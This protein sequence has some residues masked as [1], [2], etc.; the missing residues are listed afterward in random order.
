MSS[1]NVVLLV[2]WA[3][4]GNGF[5]LGDLLEERGFRVRIVGIP[6]YSLRNRQVKWRKALLWW[7]YVVLGYRGAQLARR[8]ASTVVAWNFIPGVFAA[9]VNQVFREPRVNVVSLNAIAFSKGAMHSFARRLV[10]RR[11]FASGR[12]WL[13]VNS[14]ALRTL[15]GQWFGFTRSRVEV[16]Y[17]CWSPAYKVGGPNGDD[18]GYVFAGG[19]AARDWPLVLEIAEQLPDVLFEVVAPR[20]DWPSSRSCPPNVHVQFDITEEDFYSLLEGSRLV[21]MPLNSTVTAGLIVLMRA[22][23]LGRIVVSTR[24]PATETCYPREL[25]HLLVEKGDDAGFCALIETLWGDADARVMAARLL[26]DHV[27]AERSPFGFADRV[28]EL[29]RRADRNVASP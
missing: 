4:D 18:E 19:E 27:Y 6:N 2:D 9:I 23:L 1:S 28:A 24:T 26:Q 12:L 15:Y 25:R 14:H 10:Y 22:A 16:L 29:V 11:A 3:A 20:K 7:Q 8:T 13:T 21:L 5:W 17:D